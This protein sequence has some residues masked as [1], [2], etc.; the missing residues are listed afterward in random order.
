MELVVQFDLTQIQPAYSVTRVNQK[1]PSFPAK[2]PNSA[3]SNLSA[4]GES[5]DSNSW[6]L[7][8]NL[9]TSLPIGGVEMVRREAE[10]GGDN[11]I[12]VPI[13]FPVW[14]VWKHY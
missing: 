9:T 14:S 2:E 3:A 10:K 7:W 5:L 12:M 4:S 8:M 6:L 13:G 11:S 1:L